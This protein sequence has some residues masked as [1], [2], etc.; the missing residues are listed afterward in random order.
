MTE[1]MAVMAAREVRLCPWRMQACNRGEAPCPVGAVGMGSKVEEVM[2]E[3][4]DCLYAGDELAP[5]FYRG[6]TAGERRLYG[7][8]LARKT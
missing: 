7:S 3:A 4:F 1:E 8:D 2:E 6:L 5:Y